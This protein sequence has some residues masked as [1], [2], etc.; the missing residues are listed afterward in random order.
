MLF[1]VFGKVR[2]RVSEIQSI[3]RRK[4][5]SAPTLRLV[6]TQAAAGSIGNRSVIALVGVKHDYSKNHMFYN[7]GYSRRN[8]PITR[9]EMNDAFFSRT[10]KT[11]GDAGR[12]RRGAPRTAAER[13]DHHALEPRHDSVARARDVAVARCA[14]EAEGR[15]SAETLAAERQVST[16]TEKRLRLETQ[17]KS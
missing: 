3:L 14:E 9:R 1:K 17:K 16:E 8:Q 7:M 6:L 4:K 10:G 12:D 5:H 2:E 15:R 11:I 13:R